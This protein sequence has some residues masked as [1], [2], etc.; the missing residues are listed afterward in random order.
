M[1]G[2]YKFFFAALTFAIIF[3]V[4]GVTFADGSANELIAKIE[5]D[6]YGVEQEGALL[7]RINQLEKDYSGKNLPENM[8]TRIEA[9]YTI[10]Y[11]NSAAP[12]I[13]SKINAMEWNLEHEVRGGGVESRLQHLEKKILGE[14]AQGTF[15]ERV[16]ELIIASFGSEN[17][18]MAE[19]QLPADTLIKIEIVD[20]VNTRTAQ[21]GDTIRFRVIEDV[22]IDGSLVFAKG[23]YGYGEISSVTKATDWGR[24]G[25]LVVDFHSL[26]GLDGQEVKTYVGDAAISMM[27][28]NK[29]V[30][31]GALVGLNLSEEW[32]KDFV[33]GKNVD[34]PSESQLYI[35]TKFDSAVY[36]LKGGRGTLTIAKKSGNISTEDL[37]D[38][39]DLE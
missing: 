38:F 3:S 25:K 18:P 1:K 35:Q 39:K 11:D 28:E 24:N 19:M 23:L 29:M 27:T 37:N 21:I 30:T 6:T 14:E 34:V 15:I 4:S 20:N 31:G 7:P 9:L 26:T 8:N 33:F 5:R 17:I 2:A 36:A 10:L 12:S 13:I 22:I 16:R 32:N